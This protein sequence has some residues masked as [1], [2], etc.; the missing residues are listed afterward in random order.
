MQ[1]AGITPGFPLTCWVSKG[2]EHRIP[3]KSR[4]ALSRVIL[5]GIRDPEALDTILDSSLRWN[6][7]CASPGRPLNAGALAPIGG[8]FTS[9]VLPGKGHRQVS[10]AGPG[11]AGHNDLKNYLNTSA[12]TS[13]K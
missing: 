8:Q 12:Q 5:D 2:V 10:P 1:G 11:R 3:M 4:N 13:P 7:A 9:A 6:D